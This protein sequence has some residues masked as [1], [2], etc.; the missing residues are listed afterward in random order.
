MF[1]AGKWNPDTVLVEEE[2][3]KMGP[4]NEAA[5]GCSV[6]CNTKNVWRAIYTR[7]PALLKKLVADKSKIFT[8]NRAWS[9]SMDLL[10]LE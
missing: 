10:P 7:N 1:K 6:P 5:Y 9:K 8:L 2:T 4:S 3:E